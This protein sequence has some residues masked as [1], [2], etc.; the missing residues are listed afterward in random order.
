MRALS[1]AKGCYG[2]RLDLFTNATVGDDNAIRLVL[3]HEKSTTTG[4]WN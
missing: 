3:E 1:V 2:M 4:L